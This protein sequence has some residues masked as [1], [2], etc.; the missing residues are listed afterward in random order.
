MGTPLGL[1]PGPALEKGV[2]SER[3][4]DGLLMS[5]DRV[6]AGPPVGHAGHCGISFNPPVDEET[7]SQRD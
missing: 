4:E 5:G 1:A 2:K 3:E 7:E 6:E